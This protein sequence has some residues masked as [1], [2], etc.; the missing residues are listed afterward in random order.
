MSE[1]NN[2]FIYI[3]TNPA[4]KENL[5]KIG[6]TEKTPDERAAGLSKSTGVPAKFQPVHKVEVSSYWKPKLVE[7]IIHSRLD[8][9]RYTEDREFFELPLEK[10]V[11]VVDIIAAQLD[12]M[13][14][15]INKELEPEK[16]PTVKPEADSI[17]CDVSIVKPEPEKK[18]KADNMLR[19]D[20]LSAQLR[21]DARTLSVRDVRALIK[22]H[23]F[24]CK[25]YSWSEKWYNESGDFKNDLTDNENGT[26][27]DS[28]TDL[29]WEK[30]GSSN[31][32]PFSKA[33]DYIDGLNRDKFAGYNDWRL[34]TLEELA[35]LL[36]NKKVD[37]LYI[38]SLF[39]RNQWYCWTADTRAS[40]GAWSVSF[41]GGSVRWFG[42][43]NGDYVRAVRSRTSCKSDIAETLA[44][45]KIREMSKTVDA[46]I[47]KPTVKPEADVSVVKP[48]PEK[49]KPEADNMLRSDYL[50]AQLRSDARTLSARD[51]RV[52][53]KKHNFYCCKYDWTKRWYNES[54]DFKNDFTD[55][56][57]GTITDSVTGLVWKKSGLSDYM[58]IE[59]YIDGLNKKK[60]VGHNDWRLPTLEEL[61]SLLE[62]K[63]VNGYY[64]DP[65]FKCKSDFG[66]YWTADK[67]AN[68]YA[69]GVHFFEGYVHW[70]FIPGLGY[71]R[72]VR[73]L[74]SCKSDIAEPGRLG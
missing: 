6:Y 61:A 43:D 67:H 24:Y 66:W 12:M 44:K 26:I 46:K 65:V 63:R 11:R 23:N 59:D 10:A 31:Y 16:K 48:E 33:Q 58:S 17:L 72:A 19:S 55:N 70:D 8:K 34:P 15:I 39:D 71:V 74:T 18:P 2:G 13:S 20:Y 40:E 51:V 57:N 73:S 3:L 38:D 64:I 45:K 52:L 69:W 28:V 7:Q 9:F 25:E 4:Y 53:I 62:R 22:K 29:V 60:F 42:L 14:G 49:K 41:L 27:T 68:G 30:A 36:E 56:G 32:M 35:S 1:N 21:S 47:E 50:S 5:Y 54:G 37:G